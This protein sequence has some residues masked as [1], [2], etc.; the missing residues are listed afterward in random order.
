[1]N[2]SQISA[3]KEPIRVLQFIC[4]TGYYGAERWITALANNSDSKLVEQSLVVTVE[5]GDSELELCRVFASLG[6]TVHEIKMGHKFD[7]RSIFRLKRL[8]IEH[9]ID[10]LHTHGYKSDLIGVIAAKMAGIACVCTPHG[11]ENT[12]DLKL[13]AF[14]ALGNMS[15]RFFDRVVPLS[16]TLCTDVA[17]AGV[18]D[19]R[20]S[21]IANGVDL[22][23]IEQRRQALERSHATEI[24]RKD[25]GE[26]TV[27][28][29]GQLISR[30][31]VGDIIDMVDN[32]STRYDNVRLLLIGDGDQRTALEHKVAV[33]ACA[34][35]IKFCGFVADAIPY[36][37]ELD[38]F[39]MTSS[40]EGIP[41]CVMEAMTAGVPVVAYDIPGVDQLIF[42]DE[43]GFL[44]PFGDKAA[45]ASLCERILFEPGVGRRLANAARS[46]VEENHSAGRMAEEYISL[47]RE[48]IEVSG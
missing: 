23:D 6:L 47:Y 22:K 33:S 19:K 28:F 42:H 20:I 7:L 13:R 31:N 4:P 32:L 36:Y 5:P 24:P 14:I 30:K 8:L 35:K 48:V 39:V 1:M 34:D 18:P 21:Y 2:A 15:F 11:F 45:L 9:Q 40:L 41:R 38:A 3:G 27:G 29:I 10:V 25:D 46:Y 26:L 37:F 43:T 44:A 17:N 12:N 16:R